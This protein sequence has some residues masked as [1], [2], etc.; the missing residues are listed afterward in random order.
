MA[1][2]LPLAEWATGTE[3]FLPSVYKRSAF[4]QTNIVSFEQLARCGLLVLVLDG[5]NELDVSSTQRARSQ[6]QCS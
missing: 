4:K 1:L 5:W 2:F 6:D 3:D